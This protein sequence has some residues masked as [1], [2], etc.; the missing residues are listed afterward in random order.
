MA[1]DGVRKLEKKFKEGNRVRVRILGFR[2]LEGVATGT[3][4]VV[5][6]CFLL[7]LLSKEETCNF[8]LMIG[9]YSV[10]NICKVDISE[11]LFVY[12]C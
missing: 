12:F 4:K 10:I 6:H 8:M 3:L 9:L 1:E 7:M 2:H 5:F 11:S